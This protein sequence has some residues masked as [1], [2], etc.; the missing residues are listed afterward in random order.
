[1]SKLSKA[2]RQAIDN[3]RGERRIGRDFIEQLGRLVIFW[4]D[5]EALIRTLALM[6]TQGLKY[7]AKTDE[8]LKAEYH[9]NRVPFDK[10]LKAVFPHQT[11]MAHGILR[12][13]DLR[14]FALHGAVGKRGNAKAKGETD[15]IMHL[16][17]PATIFAQEG[18]T[19]RPLES[20]VPRARRLERSGVMGAPILS[21]DGL[22]RACNDLEGYVYD[23]RL[24]R[25]AI[26]CREEEAE[27]LC[28]RVC[29][30]DVE[31]TPRSIEASF[32]QNPADVVGHNQ[33]MAL[34]LGEFCRIFSLLA[35]TIR[36]LEIMRVRQPGHFQAHSEPKTEVWYKQSTRQLTARL[37]FILGKEN[38]DTQM[39]VELVKFR[40][41][42]YHNP[43]SLIGAG[44][45]GDRAVFLHQDLVAIRD[46]RPRSDE[47]K[48]KV[49]PVPDW[50]VQ[51]H[52]GTTCVDVDELESKSDEAKLWQERLYKLVQY[53]H[54]HPRDS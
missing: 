39:L 28:I 23:L 31:K 43:I 48:N 35:Q 45:K 10:R 22:R 15:V 38:R 26:Q 50:A 21:T 41:F 33:E 12:L 53:G 3:D 42:V 6:K 24:F 51:Q 7:R 2:I 40:N 19:S 5:I 25:T 13:K 14:D 34:R 8:E 16:D 30:L 54:R 49:R 4:G 47:D 20:V 27:E 32:F 52:K 9:R 36:T 1:M 46:A 37:N 18:Y 29:G 17:A 44:S 11:A